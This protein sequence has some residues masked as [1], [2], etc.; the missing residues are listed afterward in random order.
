MESSVLT[1]PHK[2]FDIITPRRKVYHQFNRLS[3]QSS[4]IIELEY[5]QSEIALI[6]HFRKCFNTPDLF[7]LSQS[8]LSSHTTNHAHVRNL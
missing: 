1:Q 3:Y 5:K 6:R 2:F 8:F 4:S 7:S